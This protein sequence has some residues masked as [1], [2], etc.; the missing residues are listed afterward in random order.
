MSYLHN[1][2]EERSVQVASE[3]RTVQS[4]SFQISNLLII[5]VHL[6]ISRREG[7]FKKSIAWLDLTE[8]IPICWFLLFRP[9]LCQS[10]RQKDQ[11]V[12]LILFSELNELFQLMVMWLEYT[13]CIQNI[14]LLLFFYESQELYLWALHCG[15]KL[16]FCLLCLSDEVKPPVA[17]HGLFHAPHVQGAFNQYWQGQSGFLTASKLLEN[18]FF[19]Q[20]DGGK[21]DWY[22]FEIVIFTLR[23]Y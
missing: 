12:W 19:F 15:P 16:R 23:S 18:V 17:T 4:C 1:L 6:A 3:V 14:F 7:T 9:N 10:V 20:L 21:K 8:K 5:S 11:I 13:A 2:S 22:R